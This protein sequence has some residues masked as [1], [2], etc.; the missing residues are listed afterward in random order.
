MVMIAARDAETITADRWLDSLPPGSPVFLDT[1]VLVYASFPEL[2]LSDVARRRLQALRKRELPIWASRQVFREFLATATR[3]GTLS[4]LA[5]VALI[6]EALRL[7]AGQL[8]VAEDDAETTEHLLRLLENPGARGKQVH[9]ANIVATM[10]RH[11]I[12]YLLTHNGTDFE[13]YASL[14]TVLPLPE[15]GS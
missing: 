6:V 14:V 8:T 5:P 10:Q 7:W 9:D 1:N 11:G 4:S 13:R 12:R 15:S 2:S 3:P